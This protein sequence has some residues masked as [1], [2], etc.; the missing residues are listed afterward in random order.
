MTLPF[1]QAVTIAAICYSVGVLCGLLFSR[2]LN[3]DQ[4]PP[5]GGAA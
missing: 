5:S 4:Q 3:N 2:F 1:D